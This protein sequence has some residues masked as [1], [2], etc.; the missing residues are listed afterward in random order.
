MQ[1][2]EGREK[3]VIKS[4]NEMNSGSMAHESQEYRELEQ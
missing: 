1:G 3:V 4:K 2:G